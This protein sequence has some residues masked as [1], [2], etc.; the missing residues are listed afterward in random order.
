MDIEDIIYNLARYDLTE[1]STALDEFRH[2]IDADRVPFLEEQL[3]L[4]RGQQEALAVLPR[5]WQ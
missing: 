3:E 1:A 2:Q 5:S 4:M